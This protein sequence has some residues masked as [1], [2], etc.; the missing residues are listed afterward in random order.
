MGGESGE[1]GVIHIG[2]SSPTAEELVAINV[3]IGTTTLIF[4]GLPLV[5]AELLFVSIEKVVAA[6]RR[7]I[8]I[9]N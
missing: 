5:C 6:K 9:A 3:C 7:S 8:Y 4:G 1:S 2:D